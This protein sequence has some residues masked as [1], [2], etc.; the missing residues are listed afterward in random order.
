MANRPN[1]VVGQCSPE[2]EHDLWSS[3]PSRRHILCHIELA[4]RRSIE[5]PAETKIA[6]LQFTVRIHQQVSR[7]EISVDN[8]GCLKNQE[9]LRNRIRGVGVSTF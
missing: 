4:F 8:R 9:R 1:Q 6:Y 3:I 7:F 2:R 5:S